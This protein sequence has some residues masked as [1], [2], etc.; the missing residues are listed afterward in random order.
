[1]QS[2]DRNT[3]IGFVLLGI[4][5]ILFT[6]YNQPSKEQLAIAKKKKD[7]IEL[8]TKE[9]YLRDSLITLQKNNQTFLSKDSIINS[10]SVTN[11]QNSKKRIEEFYVLENDLLKATVSNIGAR[12]VSVELKNKKTWDDKPLVLFSNPNTSYGYIMLSGAEEINTKNLSFIVDSTNNSNSLILTTYANDKSI[13]FKYSVSKDSYI[14]NYDVKL[15]GATNDIQK[16]IFNWKASLNELEQSSVNEIANSSIYYK[17][18]TEDDVEHI[19]E[20]SD[21]EQNIPA[22]IDWLSF[23]Q[24]YFNSTI[25]GKN[26]F[27]S[28]NIKITPNTKPGVLKNYEAD[29]VMNYKRGENASY[30]LQF[31]FSPNDYNLLKKYNNELQHI[32]PLGWGIFGWFSRPVNKWFIIPMFDFF[33]NYISN[34]GIIILII[35]VLLKI[36]LFPLTYRSLLSAAKMRVLKPEID[37][38]K[39]KY[40]EDQTRFG[41]EQL[42][43]FQKA[44]VN[45]LGG[46]IPMLLQMPILIAMYSYFPVSIELRQ[47]SFLWAND[48]STYD[49]IYNFPNH[50]SLPFYGSHVS[51]FTLLMTV[52]SIVFA[53]YNNQLTGVTGQMKWMA[54]IFPVML[55]GVF[56]NLSSGLTYYYF[57]SNVISFLQQFIVQKVFINEAAIHKQIQENKKKTPKKSGFMQRLENMQRDQKELQQKR[58]K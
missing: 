6:V 57:L 27:E 20:G 47:Q 33:N 10:D 49:S 40:A 52:S 5:L 26:A 22:G 30:N 25:L 18:S 11:N 4:L 58:K 48:L 43:L 28:G 54:Y 46:C 24:Q 53:I 29:L 17:F 19:T 3:I 55:L 8:V 32:I 21:G 16:L 45:P 34:Y 42:K 36:L 51:L 35:T 7:S 2:L 13:S 38:L 37:E 1:L 56:N 23:K 31:N 15:N 9:N 39:A 41:Q 12:I 50:F 44:G 14:I